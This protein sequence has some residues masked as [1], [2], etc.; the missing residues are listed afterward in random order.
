MALLK[1]R[2]DKEQGRA[3]I[4]MTTGVGKTILATK[5]LRAEL[6]K[7]PKARILWLTHTGELLTQ[8]KKELEIIS[9]GIKVGIVSRVKKEWNEQIIVASIPTLAKK[10]NLKK[11]AKSH[12]K[13]LMVDE[14]HHTPAKT[15]KRILEYFDGIPIGLTASPYRPDSQSLVDFFGEPLINLDYNAAV[16]KRLIAKDR[17]WCILTN[18]VLHGVFGTCLR[19]FI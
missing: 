2:L 5:L 13:M 3:L 11:L 4:R 9:R 15:W 7:N 14:C 17:A 19:P 12:F 18:S 10:Y 1:Q 16:K 6:K 8:A